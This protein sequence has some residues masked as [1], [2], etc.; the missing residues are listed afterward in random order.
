MSVL[1]VVDIIYHSFEA[2]FHRHHATVNYYSTGIKITS[3]LESGCL[4]WN[5][6]SV[7]YKLCELGKVTC[8]FCA[9]VS[10]SIKQGY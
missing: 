4:D 5:L 8:S 1:P 2:I 3:S 10:S 6:T 7:I 9:L